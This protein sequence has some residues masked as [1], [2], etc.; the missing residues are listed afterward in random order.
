MIVATFALDGLDDDG[1]NIHGFLL[2]HGAEFLLGDLF[3]ADDVGKAFFLRQRKVDHRGADARPGELGEVCDLPRVGVRQAHRV[4]GAAVERVFEMD[5]FRAAL[6]ATSSNVFAHLPIHR[7]LESV[8]DGERAAFDEEVALESRMCDDAGEGFDE[9]GVLRRVNIR[10][11]HLHLGGAK[12]VRL[13]VGAA[14]VGMVVADGLRRVEAVEVDEL[15]P[16]CGIYEVRAVAFLDVKDQFETVHQDVL[17]QR[18]RAGSGQPLAIAVAVLGVRDCIIPCSSR[19]PPMAGGP[20]RHPAT[21]CT[22]MIE[23]GMPVLARA[24]GAKVQP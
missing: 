5:D 10:V 24:R 20:T 8:L 12:Q 21:P 17:L 18:V 19:P 4:A 2:E 13:H 6:T 22:S 14:E 9:R 11:G 15:A 7:G 16:G 3:L 1:G 23:S